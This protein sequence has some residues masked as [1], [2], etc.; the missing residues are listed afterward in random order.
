MIDNST[1]IPELND[2]LIFIL[3]R[4]NF[5]CIHIAQC[6]RLSGEIISKRAEDEQ[7]AA[8]RWMLNLYFKHGVNWLDEAKKEIK[9]ISDEF[10]SKN[11]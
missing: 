4:P 9:R 2:E 3:G 8:I 7:A 1:V 10:G 5:K 6:L 11:E